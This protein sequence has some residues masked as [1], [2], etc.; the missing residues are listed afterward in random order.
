MIEIIRCGHDSRRT[1]ALDIIHHT[2]IDHY[3]LLLIK[4]GAYVETCG[5]IMEVQPGTAVLF[6]K[7]KRIHYGC[8]ENNYNDDWIHFTVSPDDPILEQAGIPFGI[9]FMPLAFSDLAQYVRLLVKEK[10]L[11]ST[12]G[13]AILDSLMH[14]FLLKLREQRE[15]NIPALT[16]YYFE[17]SRL[18]EE[19]I[20]APGKKWDIAKMAGNLH[21]SV[22]YFQHLYKEAFGIPCRKDIILARIS[23]SK[24]YLEETDMKIADIAVFCGY[25]EE[26]HY[27]KQ[28]K[29]FE[30]I[31]PSQYRT[32]FLQIDRTS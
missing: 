19:I 10:Y 20:N 9:P 22:S 2:G 14:A 24:F 26:V 17:F 16:P 1:K 28:F 3:L 7:N 30:G 6:D 15:K 25:E 11:S 32:L 21:M 31:T 13:P 18:R 23:T 8:S 29:K 12:Y 27:M 5:E 4:T